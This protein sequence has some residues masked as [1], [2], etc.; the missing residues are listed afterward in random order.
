MSE[1]DAAI[2]RL[3]PRERECLRLAGS[4]TSKDIARHLGISPHTV[5]ERIAA[6]VK[7]LGASD[8]RAAARLLQGHEGAAA[9]QLEDPAPSGEAGGRPPNF[10]G[11]QP[12]GLGA[13]A[14]AGLRSPLGDDGA[15]AGVAAAGGPSGARPA[16]LFRGKPVHE[17]GTVER[18]GAILLIALVSLVAVLLL[19]VAAQEMISLL[20]RVAEEPSSR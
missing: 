18:G 8:R 5:D 11:P 13:T 12:A 6:A 14:A 10:S 19:L 15:S 17:W 4:M 3:T 20:Q 2:A 9:L 16:A 1:L 7:K